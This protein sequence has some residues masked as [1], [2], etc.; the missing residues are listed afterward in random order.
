[1]PEWKMHL[2]CHHSL[3]K[4]FSLEPHAAA[5][6]PLPWLSAH[7]HGPKLHA[8]M[9]PRLFHVSSPAPLFHCLFPLSLILIP[10]F[11]FIIFPPIFPLPL[12]SQS[13]H[14]PNMSHFKGRLTP[15]HFWSLYHTF[16]HAHGQFCISK[17]MPHPV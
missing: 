2:S 4:A 14:I 16:T 13:T 11:I 6:L 3:D 9:P 15:Y 17:V 7:S 10:K 1:M 5:N 8:F 12:P